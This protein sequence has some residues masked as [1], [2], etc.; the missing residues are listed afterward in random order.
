MIFSFALWSATAASGRAAAPLDFQGALHRELA[1]LAS[2]WSRNYRCLCSP[3]SSSACSCLPM[4]CLGHVCGLARPRNHHPFSLRLDFRVHC[5]LQ[6]RDLGLSVVRVGIATSS[7]ARS[8][9]DN[10]PT[11]CKTSRLH[12]LRADDYV[13]VSFLSRITRLR[14]R[15]KS[16]WSANVARRAVDF[17]ALGFQPRGATSDVQG[18]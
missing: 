3:S 8:A 4:R 13:P 16:G 12:C 15:R 9:F 18:G 14:T 5:F 6:H 7:A 2:L 17:V 1:G 11:G 10:E